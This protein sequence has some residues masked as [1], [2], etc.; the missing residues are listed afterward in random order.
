MFLLYLVKVA[1]ITPADM[2]TLR[3]AA[4]DHP[5]PLLLDVREECV[6]G[7]VDTT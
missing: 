2:E 5:V 3:G 1:Q 6:V 7:G 4:G